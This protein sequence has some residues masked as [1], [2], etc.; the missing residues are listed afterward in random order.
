[1][2]EILRR[3]LHL[4]DNPLGGFHAIVGAWLNRLAVSLPANLRPQFFGRGGN[5]PHRGDS[6]PFV[7][8]IRGFHRDVSIPQ[9][10]N[11]L[12][13]IGSAGIERH[14]RYRHR[15]RRRSARQQGARANEEQHRPRANHLRPD[16]L[17]RN[18]REP[19]GLPFVKSKNGTDIK[20]I[21]LEAVAPVKYGLVTALNRWVWKR[22]N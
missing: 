17:Y 20:I 7:V 13:N 22:S 10:C 12:A 21:I 9:Q 11:F 8:V 2:P 19:H 14:W 16:T 5:G 1:L 3:L 4:L 15:P 6:M 18:S